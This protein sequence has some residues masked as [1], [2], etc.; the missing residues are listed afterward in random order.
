[1]T[2]PEFNTIVNPSGQERCYVA[3]RRGVP[4]GGRLSS[5]SYPDIIKLIRE[6]NDLEIGWIISEG[7]VVIQTPE[8]YLENV[9]KRNKIDTIIIKDNE[10]NLNL[11]FK[12]NIK[13][14]TTNN[15]LVCGATANIKVMSNRPKTYIV[16]PFKARGNIS[17]ILQSTSLVYNSN[18][19]GLIPNWMA[20]TQKYSREEDNTSWELPMTGSPDKN[21]KKITEN[22]KK[23]NGPLNEKVEIINFLNEHFLEIPAD[24]EILANS[25]DKLKGEVLIS[26]FFTDKGV[27]LHNVLG[28]SLIKMCQ[29][30][31]CSS[32]KQLYY[33]SEEENLYISNN[34]Y[35]FG[36]MT[37]LC[38]Q[39][40]EFQ[41]LETINYIERYLTMEEV[42]FNS[43]PFTIVFKNGVLDL[44]TMNVEPM[45]PE[46]LENIR[47]DANYDPEAYSE[48]A[49]EFFKTATSGDKDIETLLFEAIGYS[50]LKTSE[51]Q[52]AF[53]LVG[54]GRNG[55]STYLDLIK[56]ILGKHNTTAISFQDM[57]KNF[58][59]SSL[60]NKLASIAG[61]VSNQAIPESDTLK[62]I[63][64]GEDVMLEAKYKEAYQKSLFSTMFFSCNTL[65]RTPDTS[66]GFYRRFAIIPFVANLDKVSHVEG[67]IFKENL[68]KQESVD[69]VAYKSV[70]AINKVLKTTHQ[71]TQPDAVLR[72]KEEY[73]IE[74][75]SV[76]SWF[77]QSSFSGSKD[78][79]IN[80][81]ISDLYYAYRSWALDNG[82]K[83]IVRS[84]RFEIEMQ[85]EFGIDIDDVS[86][87]IVGFL[88]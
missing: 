75:S 72:M 13:K 32:N 81:N 85:T 3:L 69:Y 12:T 44:R 14:G 28:E 64:G 86:G 57:A 67:M 50:M 2:F 59:L 19:I 20:P 6:T 8:K 1:M 46:K 39:L 23:F 73:K 18:K 41:K 11:I 34:D 9:I 35:L 47:I 40:R 48:T 22:L 84:T 5:L 63:I 68:L 83:G 38:P 60:D 33:W 61:D 37:R 65:P 80:R 62:S 45:T 55:K 27:F 43:D 71:F 51:L 54:S 17:E 79:L 76:L 36:V 24:E 29:I 77:Y 58:R 26:E 21:I 25:Y 10:D 74:N 78:A 16:L 15:T 82:F 52:T 87:F 70:M 53:L 66:K 31:K 4:V 49:D 88:K 7:Y 56:A 30:K 42:N